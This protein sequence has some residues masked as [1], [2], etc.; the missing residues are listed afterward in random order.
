MIDQ[1]IHENQLPHEDR[2]IEIDLHELYAKLI[3]HHK[4]I[5]NF[6][7]VC[8]GVALLYSFI[9]RPVYKSTARIMVEGKAPKITKVDDVVLNPDY[10]DRTNYYN[11]QIEVLKSHAVGNL[12]FADLG[13]YQPWGSLRGRGKDSGKLTKD[14]R[15]NKL[16]KT[17]RIN[18]VRMTQIIEISAEDVDRELAAKIANSWV[19]SYIVFSSLDQLIQRRSELEAD[20][21][22]NLKY[23][24]EKH[25]IIQGLRSEISAIDTKISGEKQKSFN[26]NVKVLDSGQVSRKPVRPKPLLNLIF[27][28]FIGAFGGIGFVFLLENMDQSI[29]HQ[30]DV[31][32]FLHM[33]CL[34]A[35]PVYL[36][37]AGKE[38]FPFGLIS[39][40]DINSMFAERLRGLRTSIIYSNPDLSKKVLQITSAGPA[41][42]KSTTAVNL[43]TVFAHSEGK[44]ILI[45]ADLRKPTL[46]SIFNLPC[47]KGL[48][49]L[50]A[51]EKF[52]F[53]TCI[54]KTNIANL[55]FIS[56]GTIPLNPAELLGSKK[57]ELLIS[58]LSKTYDRIIFDAPPVLAATD[59]VILSTKVDATILVF[60]AGFTHKLAATRSA[61]LIHSVHSKVL[62][63]VL[64]MVKAE[65]HKYY[66]Y[67]NY[68]SRDDKKA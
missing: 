62:G 6:I 22:Q 60:K 30:L 15:V 28:F 54:K 59:A 23:V 36:P 47:E 64:N 3:K 55:D 7:Y 5:L 58:E 45:D 17:I 63:V 44:I 20:I 4:L 26:A 10:V 52:D 51:E 34:T 35:L 65:D 67:Y 50:L 25:P 2:F 41:E 8:V 32:S 46:H 16:L 24:K 48:T 61:R 40:K 49:E 39:A 13:G 38:I 56:C 11:S 42:G 27:A 68:Y 31:E 66:P 43:A 19:N 29:K 37:E 33:P 12:V 57:L 1:N 14:E 21:D 53:K 9:A 18:P